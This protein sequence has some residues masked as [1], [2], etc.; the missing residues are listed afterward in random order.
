M[1]KLPSTKNCENCAKLYQP[2]HAKGRFCSNNCR[3]QWNRK[4][5]K[6]NLSNEKENKDKEYIKDLESALKGLKND[7]KLR[8]EVQGIEDNILMQDILLKIFYP[9]A[10]QSEIKATEKKGNFTQTFIIE[11]PKSKGHK[12]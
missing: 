9:Y 7:V 3:S 6:A 4:K 1:P 10:V 11:P 2:K 5:I 8:I 12:I